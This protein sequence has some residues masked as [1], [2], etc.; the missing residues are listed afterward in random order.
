MSGNAP[1]NTGR[2]RARGDRF[3]IGNIALLPGE[4]T[5]RRVPS[6]PRQRSRQSAEHFA[7]LQAN[8][9]ARALRDA[10]AAAAE[11]A[12][13][14]AAQPA[15]SHLPESSAG[16]D[17]GMHMHDPPLDL[18]GGMGVAA[19]PTVAAVGRRQQSKRVR[20]RRD[21]K[22][23]AQ[24]SAAQHDRWK[25]VI[26][27]LVRFCVLRHGLFP[28]GVIRSVANDN[29][30]APAAHNAA[31]LLEWR[32]RRVQCRIGCCPVC[33][34]EQA[35][36][37][38]VPGSVRITYCSLSA[39][40]VEIPRPSFRCTKC[41]QTHAPHPVLLG[42]FPSSP[43]SSGQCTWFD[44]EVMDLGRS[45]MRHGHYPLSAIIKVSPV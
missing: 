44:N 16:G 20:R 17:T 18:V 24:L 32:A 42:V 5:F 13:E 1:S 43:H 12:V 6:P 35:Q 15:L 45:L 27:D 30:P 9:R 21:R 23:G 14:A 8:K 37:T 3:Y 22:P 10:E 36:Q 19:A 28:N 39:D 2:R 11:A 25:G 41:G 7:G 40:M 34:D 31:A 4:N 38:A 26:P 29:D 33:G